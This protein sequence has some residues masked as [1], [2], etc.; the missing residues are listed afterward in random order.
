M[1]SPENPHIPALRYPPG[2]PLSAHLRWLEVAKDAVLELLQLKYQAKLLARA[3]ANEPATFHGFERDTLATI[4]NF[5]CEGLG[6]SVTHNIDLPE[7]RDGDRFVYVCNHPTLT[8]VWPWG[9]FMSQ[10]FGFNLVAVGKRDV[11]ENPLSRW[12][13]GDLMLTAQ[14]GIFIDRSHR[15]EAIREIRDHAARVLT[16]NTGAVIFPDMHRPYPGRIRRQRK[17]WNK[18]RPDLHFNEWLTETCFPHSGG[19]W[20]FAQAIDGLEQVRFL[21]CTVFEPSSAYR[22]GGQLHF[23]VREISRGELLGSSESEAY[24]REKLVELWKRKNQMI[25]EWRS[26]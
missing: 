26:D 18:K 9:Q 14:K 2:A 3:F 7:A 5:V 22:Y 24:L 6:W 1:P 11:I 16:P 15:G 17:K 19:L 21:D 12:F 4:G 10:H 20:A 13:L 25:K 8:A 23:N